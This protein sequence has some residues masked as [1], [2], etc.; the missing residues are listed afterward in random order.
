MLKGLITIAGCCTTLWVAAQGA[1]EVLQQ[2]AGFKRTGDYANAALTLRKGL[3]ANPASTELRQ[4]LAMVYYLNRQN[5]AALEAIEPLLKTDK[6]DETT[7][8]LAGLIYRNSLDFKNAETLYKAA[9]KKYPKSGLLHA[10][11]GEM[12]DQK[13][14]GFGN[15]LKWYEAGIAAQP[16]YPANYYHAAKAYISF[17]PIRALLYSEIFVNMESYSTRTLEIKTMMLELYSKLWGHGLVGYDAKNP[18]DKAVAEILRPYANLVS[19]GITLDKLAMVRARF[20]LDW[21]NGPADKYPY[22]LFE[23]QRQLMRDGHFEAYNQW[24][25]GSVAN[26]PAFQAYTSQNKAAYDAF[27]QM[28]RNRVF[29]MPEGQHYAGK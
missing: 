16:D 24:L 22:R 9:L 26:L 6:A 14:P 27:T 15:G 28:Q 7:Y 5:K 29:K 18:F 8:Q 12:L 2:A 20:I 11:Y 3:E 23:M 10:D 13:D 19:S 25:L 17:E 1:N 4:E 21:F